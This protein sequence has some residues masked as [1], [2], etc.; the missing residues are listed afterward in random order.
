MK[1]KILKKLKLKE[2]LTNADYKDKILN[3]TLLASA[4]QDSIK[5]KLETFYQLAKDNHYQI[6]PPKLKVILIGDRMDSKVYVENKLKMCKNIGVLGE[7]K[8]FP[9]KTGKEQI[10]GEIQ[11]SNEDESVHGIIVQ[12]PLPNNL[13][14]CRTEI[15]SKVDLRKD[16]DGLNPL[17]QGKILQ[18]NLSQCL[19]P[20]TAMGVL[21][22]LRL[23]IV[24]QNNLENYINKYLS[25]YLFDDQPV[26]LSGLDI[27][28][29]GRGLTAGLPL[30]ILMQK[31]NGTV[32]TCHSKTKDINRKCET[33]DILI[34]AVGKKSLVRS[35]LVKNNSIIVDVGINVD[36]DEEG[37][38]VI[39]GDVDFIDVIDKVNYITP[40][41]GGVG[42]MTV[43]ML[44]K[45]VVK[46]WESINQVDLKE[47]KELI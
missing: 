23:G 4:I 1:T 24:Y 5:K 35:N 13:L 7:L 43:I 27:T 36:F 30:S 14:L 29:L 28:V 42:K 26:D 6:N 32:T 18:M 2:M 3:G 17:N 40:V 45:N 15:L 19:L 41:P 33:A 21:E 8:V 47:I 20:P 31:C 46:A 34:S 44:I 11:N 22:L 16:V 37:N 38:K 25:W 9:E 10:L 12:L 39:T